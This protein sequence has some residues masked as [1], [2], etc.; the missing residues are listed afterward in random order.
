MVEPHLS[1]GRS[2]LKEAG[3]HGA[4]LGSGALGS[5]TYRKWGGTCRVQVYLLA[6]E[7]KAEH[8]PEETR[9]QRAWL[10]PEA[11]SERLREPELQEMVSQLA[12]SLKKEALREGSNE[13]GGTE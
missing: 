7:G 9:R 5:Y 4:L 12:A 13:E 6:V 8:W 11:A 10:R 3:V 2:A 1:P